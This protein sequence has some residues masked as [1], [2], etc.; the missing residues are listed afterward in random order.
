MADDNKS[1]SS[2]NADFKLKRSIG[3]ITAV[4]LIAGSIVGSGIF[5]TPGGILE[6]TGS[7]G[8]SL[9]LWALAGLMAL[10]CALSYVELCL[11]IRESGAEYAIA[12]AAY[13]DWFAYL[14]AWSTAF[15]GKPG[16]MLLITFTFSEYRV[17]S[18]DFD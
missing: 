5:M 9:C 14:T 1:N 6:S 17:L 2:S 8:A 3:P 4:A 11:L 18:S 16:S 12:V 10:F 15:I 13:P 7:V